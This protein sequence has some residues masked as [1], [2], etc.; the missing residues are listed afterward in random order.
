MVSGK[1]AGHCDMTEQEIQN[2]IRLKLSEYGIVLRLNVGT[3]QTKDGRYI[4]NG[5]PPGTPD[6]LFIGKNGVAFIEVKRPGGKTSQNQENFIKILQNLGQRAGVAHSAAE[7][8]NIADI[9]E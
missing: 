9:Q 2:Q 3:F 7:A 6:L 8:L 1:I 5:L 4:S